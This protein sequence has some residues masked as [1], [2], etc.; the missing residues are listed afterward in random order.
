MRGLS[1]VRKLCDKNLDPCPFCGSQEVRVVKGIGAKF[2]QPIV[3]CANC[4]L[5]VSFHEAL[6]YIQLMEKWN[7]RSV[8]ND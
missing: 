2:A 8:G 3:L 5:T 4:G 6:T 7:G 1:M